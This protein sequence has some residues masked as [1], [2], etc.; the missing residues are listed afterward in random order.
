MADH[1]AAAVA[2]E[3]LA[4]QQVFLLGGVAGCTMPVPVH[5][6]DRHYK[7]A[8]KL[9]HGEGYKYAHDYPNHYVRQQYLPDAFKD[10]KFYHM[11]DLGYEKEMKEHMRRI[12][13]DESDEE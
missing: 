9:G 5:L 11:G 6:Q 13:G 12:R 8:A 4:G 2:T 1:G 3:N 7:G 10:Q